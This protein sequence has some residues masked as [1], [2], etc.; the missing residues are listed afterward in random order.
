MRFGAATW[1]RSGT[2]WTPPWLP[3][4][5]RPGSPRIGRCRTLVWAASWP[6]SAGSTRR[7]PPTGQH[8]ATRRTTKARFAAGPIFSRSRAAAPKRQ[9]PSTAW[10]ASWNGPAG[11]PTPAMWL[12]SRSNW[13]SRAEDAG[14]SRRL[15]DAFANPPPTRL[16]PRRWSGRLASWRW[17]ASGHRSHLPPLTER[18]ASWTSC[19]TGG[20]AWP[21][22]PT[23]SRSTSHSRPRSTPGT[24]MRPIGRPW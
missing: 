18:P 15:Q 24:S 2:A 9:H 23:R 22:R 4:A 19:R 21:R 10:P 12:A 6:G 11:W 14:S 3:I 20:P 16:P 5:R 8:S 1:R 7:W 17:T 13:P